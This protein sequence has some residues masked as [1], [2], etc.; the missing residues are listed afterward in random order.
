LGNGEAYQKNPNLWAARKEIR[1]RKWNKP[2][3]VQCS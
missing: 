1:A 3:T 2:P